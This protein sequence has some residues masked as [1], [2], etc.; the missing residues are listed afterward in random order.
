MAR[1]KGSQNIRPSKS[2]IHGYYKILR[3][4]ANSGDVN[5]AAKLIELDYLTSQRPGPMQFQ[6]TRDSR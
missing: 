3:D 6:M 2:A 4:A 5:A 1:R